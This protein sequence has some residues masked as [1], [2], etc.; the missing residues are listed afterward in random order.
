M[1]RRFTICI[2]LKTRCRTIFDRTIPITKVHI[3]WQHMHAVCFRVGD[4]LSRL[5]KTHRL[6][7]DQR[8]TKRGRIVSLEPTRNVNQFGKTS[9]VR[10]WKTILTKTADLPE[11]LPRKLFGQSSFFHPRMQLLAELFNDPGLSPLPHRSS[12]LIRFAGRKP[13]RH[14]GQLHRLL[15]ENRHAQRSMQHLLNRLV[16]V[17]RFFFAIATS[18]KRMH[19][20]AL[21]WPRSNNRDF[22]HQVV[23][24]TRPQPRQHAHLAAAFDLKHTHRIRVADHVINQR[25]LLRQIRQRATPPPMLLNHRKTTPDRRQHPQAQAVDFQQTQFFQIVFVPLD[26]RSI[27]H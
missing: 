26:H 27:V 9:R 12:Q 11:H 24:T 5:I 20:I 19:H 8:R 3:H 23:P 16:G 6:A 25:I 7:I 1:Q 17:Y 13:G 4:Q 21:D 22:D 18:Q 10:L 15:L 2:G 14:H